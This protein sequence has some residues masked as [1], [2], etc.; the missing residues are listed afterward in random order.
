MSLP[1]TASVCNPERRLARINRYVQTQ[2]VP[3]EI[4]AAEELSS[5]AKLLFARIWNLS[6][7][8]AVPCRRCLSLIA[9]DLHSSGA[10]VS[11]WY[12]ELEAAGLVRRQMRGSS[13]GA[14]VET[15]V[16]QDHPW[17]DGDVLYIPE[18]V[19][20]NV[21]P[22]AAIVAGVLLYDC[23]DWGVANVT[24]SSVASRVGLTVRQV[25]HAFAELI[26]G[27]FVAAWDGITR[28]VGRAFGFLF[29]DEATRH[30]RPGVGDPDLFTDEDHFH[31]VGAPGWW[32]GGGTPAQAAPDGGA[33]GE[34]MGGPSVE[35]STESDQSEDIQ[36][37]LPACAGEENT[38]ENEPTNQKQGQDSIPP[39]PPAPVGGVNPG[40]T[41]GDSA[42]V[43]GEVAVKAGDVEY[44]M[45][46]FRAEVG[47]EVPTTRADLWATRWLV[48]WF[49][50]DGS[51]A[52]VTALAKWW[53]GIDE[54]LGFHRPPNVGVFCGKPWLATQLILWGRLLD[55]LDRAD[56]GDLSGWLA[57]RD[58]FVD[59]G[60]AIFD[61]GLIQAVRLFDRLASAGQSAM[62][63]YGSIMSRRTTGKPVTRA[64]LR[65]VEEKTRAAKEKSDAKRKQRRP[66]DHLCA[67]WARKIQERYGDDATIT[68]W[69]VVEVQLAKKLAA[70][71]GVDKAEEVVEAFV[72]HWNGDSIPWFKACWT[73][74]QHSVGLV[75][76]RFTKTPSTRGERD[77]ELAKKDQSGWS[78]M[79]YDARFVSG[80]VVG[81]FDPEG[82]KKDQSGW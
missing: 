57:M 77:E 19:L 3:A 59:L 32:R 81:E 25:G 41:N 52:L 27:G 72:D 33:I 42:G 13:K 79:D 21:S 78:E 43:L 22:G 63:G 30:A 37:D 17:L 28:N 51:I 24:R 45:G 60:G 56:G 12:K 15:S 9:L 70:E 62:E 65:G 58:R 66:H 48:S 64:M 53:G 67:V 40:F 76:G 10:S 36:S 1:T 74:R 29:G 8:G 46:A 61:V 2:R 68:P 20:G 73:T 80:I 16:V 35:A 38:L 5:G 71:L 47:E 14:W 54:V 4:V 11:R 50:R 39:L 69:T 6:R 31:G 49:G 34:T 18:H 75:E 7:R 44:V 55:E 26:V 82:A 23:G